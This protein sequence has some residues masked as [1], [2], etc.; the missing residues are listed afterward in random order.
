MLG[1]RLSAFLGVQKLRIQNLWRQSR[2]EEAEPFLKPLAEAGTTITDEE[3][4]YANGTKGAIP[5]APP[6]PWS[7]VFTV[8]SVLNLTIYAFLAFHSLGFDQLLPIFMHHP[9]LDRDSADIQLPFKFAGGF[10]NSKPP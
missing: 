2:G 1:K 6:P 4:P 5:R 8:Q 3:S 7:S 9:V 10:G